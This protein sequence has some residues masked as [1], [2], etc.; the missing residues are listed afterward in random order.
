MPVKKNPIMIQVGSYI[1][2]SIGD[3]ISSLKSRPSTES[4]FKGLSLLVDL[5]GQEAAE[6][7]ASN[8]L[9][10]KGSIVSGGGVMTKNFRNII[11]GIK[12]DEAL[13]KTL[14]EELANLA[15]CVDRLIGTDHSINISTIDTAIQARHHNP[16]LQL[17]AREK[18]LQLLKQSNINQAS[19]S[20]QGN[21]SKAKDAF[22][23]IHITEDKV[24]MLYKANEVNSQH[25]QFRLDTIQDGRE[26][27][28]DLIVG[29]LA[30][31]MIIINIQDIVV[32]YHGRD[33]YDVKLPLAFV[34]GLNSLF[35][36]NTKKS[37][38]SR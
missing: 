3:L 9:T 33:G 7:L 37:G 20:I 15:E 10:L 27:L 29:Q 22:K 26:R 25:V 18:I 34:E 1:L 28:K 17:E 24:K 4:F 23:E 16:E 38:L 30:K 5:A 11:D 6:K 36:D 8:L 13:Q 2:S 35:S 12:K 31:R 32:E 19:S 21:F 14:N